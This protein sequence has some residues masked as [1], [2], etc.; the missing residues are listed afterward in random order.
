[1]NW[2]CFIDICSEGKRSMK[3]AP[4][5]IKTCWADRVFS[6]MTQ[7]FH[8]EV[9]ENFLLIT[10]FF[11]PFLLM[12][13]DP[14]TAYLVFFFFLVTAKPCQVFRFLSWQLSHHLSL[15]YILIKK[16]YIHTYVYIRSFR[17]GKN[18]D[19]YQNI[20]ED[21]YQNICE[22]FFTYVFHR[23]FSFTKCNNMVET[24]AFLII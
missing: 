17:R 16:I 4:L 10:A 13:I 24:I 11:F 1:M 5:C 2:A 14:K 21:R 19:K 7:M 23:L 15:L 18:A 20:C 12:V 6:P 22:L 8:I 9:S 3:F